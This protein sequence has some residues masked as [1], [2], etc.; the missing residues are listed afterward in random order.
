MK[1]RQI[2]DEYGTWTNAM[3]ELGMGVNSYRN[4]IIKKSIP[5]VTQRRIEIL[6]GGR[7]KA[8]KRLVIDDSMSIKDSEVT[9]D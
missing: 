7:L 4:W 6:T 2:L 8:D 3:H 5:L 1:L 9:T